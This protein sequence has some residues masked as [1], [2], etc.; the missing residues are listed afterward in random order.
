MNR[1]LGCVLQRGALW[2]LGL[3]CV[4]LLWPFARVAMAQ[5]A[6]PQ[7]AQVKASDAIAPTGS[8]D[9][10]LRAGIVAY[11]KRDYMSART[12]FL[13]AYQQDAVTAVAAMLADVEMKLKR[14]RDAAEHWN[15]YLNGLEPE[16]TAE[17]TEALAQIETCRRH[18]GTVKVT[19]EPKGAHVVVDGV[20]VDLAPTQ[21]DLWLEPGN[22]S[23]EV[24]VDDR[25]SEPKTVAVVPGD[26]LEV[27]LAAPPPPVL[28]AAA[29]VAPQALQPTAALRESKP[30]ETKTLVLI[31][32]GL[33]TLTGATVTSIYLLKNRSASDDYDAAVAAANAGVGDKAIVNAGSACAGGSPSEACKRVQSAAD[34]M[35]QTATVSEVALIATGVI[36][37]ATIGSYFLWPTKKEK[38]P[39]TA[40]DV[41][42]WWTPTSHGISARFGF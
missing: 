16:Q 41:S 6:A 22:H 23:I 26:K 8:S 24:K 3:T 37:V 39:S 7:Q 40:L 9:E 30:V 38:P 4:G 32:G 10:L 36:G 14:Y 34:R 35:T 20:A 15:V 33:L 18:V 28:V 29:P 19:V 27:S 13:A 1:E 21:G 5:S 42:P 31:G 17:R 11:K 2:G 12:A 25:T